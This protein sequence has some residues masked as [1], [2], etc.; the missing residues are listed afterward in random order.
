MRFFDGPFFLKEIPVFCSF[1]IR[2]WAPDIFIITYPK[3]IYHD[4]LE[5]RRMV[6]LLFYVI[7]ARRHSFSAILGVMQ[8]APRAQPPHSGLAETTRP[9]SGRPL[10][11]GRPKQSVREHSAIL[12]WSSL[13]K[14][15]RSS[16]LS[17]PGKNPSFPVIP[18]FIKPVFPLPSLPEPLKWFFVFFSEPAVLIDDL[19]VDCCPRIKN[20]GIIFCK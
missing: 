6:A 12:W 9:P 13:P 15:T 7:G 18:L 3:N 10:P 14:K 5:K 16:K 11:K 8:D 19:N 17:I 20:H 1:V 2:S 4:S